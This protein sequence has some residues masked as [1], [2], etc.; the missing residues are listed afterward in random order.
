MRYQSDS[1][2]TIREIGEKLSELAKKLQINPMS[3]D[4]DICLTSDTYEMLDRLGQVPFVCK[5]FS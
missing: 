4:S 3:K 1:C 2:S 5:I